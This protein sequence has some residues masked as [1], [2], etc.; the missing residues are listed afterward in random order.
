[1]TTLYDL[2][3]EYRQQVQALEDLDL[4]PEA[5]ADTLESLGGEL[6]VK[7]QNVVAFGRHLRTL[8]A[9]KREAAKAMIEAAARIEKRADQLDDY[10][11]HCMQAAGIQ[12]IECPWFTLSIAKNPPSVEIFDERQ[13]PSQYLTDPPPPPPRI[14]KALIKQALRDGFDV[15][16]AKLAQGVRLSIK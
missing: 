14:D 12:K 8:A 2:S 16:G 15:P 4:P 7:A 3:A 9:A 5:V 11:L 1:M 13:I 6:E 10:T